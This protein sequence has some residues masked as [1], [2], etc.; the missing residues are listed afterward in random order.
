[1]CT[2]RPTLAESLAVASG[3]FVLKLQR[4]AE[5]PAEFKKQIVRDGFFEQ[6]A[7]LVAAEAC[8]EYLVVDELRQSATDFAPKPCRPQRGRRDR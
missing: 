8:H 4:G 6:E 5:L 3:I 7:E 2:A 1:M